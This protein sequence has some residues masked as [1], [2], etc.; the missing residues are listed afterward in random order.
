[1]NG[2]LLLFLDRIRAIDRPGWE[3]PLGQAASILKARDL[4]FAGLLCQ[5]LELNAV[6]RFWY[7]RRRFG[8]D[9]HPTNMGESN[10]RRNKAYLNVCN[11]HSAFAK[12]ER[13]PR[14]QFLL[15]FSAAFPPPAHDVHH[16]AIFGKQPCVSSR[17]VAIPCICLAYLQSVDC[18]LVRGLREASRRC[19][20]S[21]DSNQN[22]LHDTP[23]IHG[24]ILP[25]RVVVVVKRECFHSDDSLLYPSPAPH[26]TH[27]TLAH[28]PW[29]TSPCHPS[30]SPSSRS[31]WMY[32]R[33]DHITA[34]RPFVI[35]L[36]FR[37]HI[38]MVS[39]IQPTF[40]SPALPHR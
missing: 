5:D 3:R 30:L 38:C 17:V 2:M 24:N 11:R 16:I 27:R 37:I 7:S 19:G 9:H 29:R 23:P 36:S 22:R 39:S 31:A 28:S 8:T 1:M 13:K 32:T 18:G 34:V 14:C 6:P 15:D 33:A 4:P 10:V 12:N 40:N 21:S 26:A 25:V 20:Y 35:G